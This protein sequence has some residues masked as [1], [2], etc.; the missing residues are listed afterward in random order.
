[1]GIRR[2]AVLFAILSACAYEE[3]TPD[4]STPPTIGFEFPNSGADEMSGTVMLPVVLSKPSDEVVTVSYSVLGGGTATPV[5][6]FQLGSNLLTFQPGDTRGEIPV[7]I[8]SDNNEMESAETFDI[9]LAAPHGA[10]LDETRAIH[11]VL[12]ADHTLP[13]VNFS[14]TTT[15]SDEGT[16]S[17]LTIE[18]TAP[19]EGPSSVVIGINTAGMPDPIDIED[20]TLTEGTVVSIPP[21]ATSVTVPIGEINDAFDEPDT[22]HATFELKGA[23]QNL[24]LGANHL[25]TFT[26][27]DND[28]TP[29]VAFSSATSN[30]NEDGTTATI[31]VTLSAISARPITVDYNRREADD[32]ADATDAVVNGTTLSFTPHSVGVT[33][34]LTKTFTVSI[35][36][37]TTDEN[38]ETVIVELANPNNNV[39]LANPTLHTLTINPDA[40]DPPPT[41]GFTTTSQTVNEA[42][43]TVNIE[44]SLSE[45]SGKTATADFTIDAA[46][47]ATNSSSGDYSLTPG[48]L[49]FT[50]GQLTANIA[51]AIHTNSPGNE[52]DETVILHLVTPSNATLNATSSTF[53]LTIKE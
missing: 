35:N 20:I 46:S 53:T 44:V 28:P 41:V 40:T 21:N 37:D 24:V 42:D 22:E 48:T 39:T 13:R 49:T 50:A 34:D 1:M 43:T 6:D 23:S 47:T 32:T 30:V 4:P 33:G 52:P 18:L 17:M 7:D 26:L 2:L 12:I 14:T 15:Q 19:S 10:L 5:D 11:E 25:D 31:T 29:T 36:N 8:V 51:V 3:P 16:P 9:G 45:V 38:A 27:A